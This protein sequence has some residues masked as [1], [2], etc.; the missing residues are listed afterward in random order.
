MAP[1]LRSMAPGLRSSRESPEERVAAPELKV[2]GGNAFLGAPGLIPALHLKLR[3]VPDC[4]G[5]FGQSG[6]RFCAWKQEAVLL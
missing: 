1:G 6:K 2:G 4:K 3:Q 5:K